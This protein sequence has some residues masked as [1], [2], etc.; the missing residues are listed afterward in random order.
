MIVKTILSSVLVAGLL[1]GCLTTT[2]QTNATMSQ[3]IFLDPVAKEKRVV[4]LN[5]KNTSGHNVNLEPKLRNALEAKGYR[6]IDDPDQANYILSTK[7]L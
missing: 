2:L 1:I 5:I 7:I 4:F 6:I 3:S